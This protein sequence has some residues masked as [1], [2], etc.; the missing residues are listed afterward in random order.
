MGTCLAGENLFGKEA[1]GADLPRSSLD[2]LA[3][4]WDSRPL[5]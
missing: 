2:E 5:P 4:G 1:V 3:L